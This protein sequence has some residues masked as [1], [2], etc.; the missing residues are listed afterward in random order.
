MVSV[1]GGSIFVLDGNIDTDQIIPP[2]Y[3]TLPPNPTNM[4]SLAV[5]LIG[6]PDH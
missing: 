2:E 5:A 4:K 3:L 6:L 1:I